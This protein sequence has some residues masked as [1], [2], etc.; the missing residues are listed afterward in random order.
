MKHLHHSSFVARAQAFVVKLH[1]MLK[2]DYSFADF[3]LAK[4][5]R[6]LQSMLYSIFQKDLSLPANVDRK[7]LTQ[8]IVGAL[9]QE[10]A[11]LISLAAI[12]TVVLM[13]VLVLIPYDRALTDHLSLR[14]AQWAHLQNLI[15]SSQSHSVSVSPPSQFDDVQL[16]GLK[17][18]LLSRDIKPPTLVISSRNPVKIEIKAN[19]VL[20]SSFLD[21]L[22]Q[23][24]IQWNL[25]PDELN[26]QATE[27]PAVVSINGYFVQQRVPDAPNSIGA[28]R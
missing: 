12:F 25:Y 1:T 11:R 26:I 20:F 4:A 18:L 7:N 2:A 19:N 15:M 8:R 27:L 22:E 13:G 17:S 23:M 9:I 24:R 6:A 3:S 14:P 5:K 10:R 28:E 21:V 16:Q